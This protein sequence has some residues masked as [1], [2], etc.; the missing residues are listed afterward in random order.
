MNATMPMNDTTDVTRV[1]VRRRVDPVV[2]A[3]TN[4]VRAAMETD[5]ETD[6]QRARKLAQLLDSQFSVAGIKFGLDAIVGLIPGVG[7]LATTLAGLYPVWVAQR[8]G[9][10]KVVRGQ[11]LLNL[12]IDFL[13]GSVPVLGDVF[14]VGFK[15]NLKNVKLLEKALAKRT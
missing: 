13:V 9:L 1:E 3:F 2:S 15:A 10:G 14:D 8:H 7:D 5:L 6:V 12:L 11:M 4:Q